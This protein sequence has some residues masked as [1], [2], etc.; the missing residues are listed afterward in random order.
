M[1]LAK[2]ISSAESLTLFHWCPSQSPQ[3]FCEAALLCL[4]HCLVT[5]IISKCVPGFW[6]HMQWNLNKQSVSLEELML[7]HANQI[8]ED[9]GKIF[10]L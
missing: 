10:F 4:K 5:L 9:A 2:T 3:R 1:T 6:L 8:H 7:F